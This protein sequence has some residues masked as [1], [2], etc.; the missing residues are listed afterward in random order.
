MARIIIVDDDELITDIV[1][2]VL[3]AAG[4]MI[5]A[6]HDGN[7]A[8][9]A[10]RAGTPDLLIL[11]YTLPGKSGMEILQE[12]RRL[13]HASS[14]PVMMLT[15]CGGRLPMARAD[16]EGADD[17]VVKPFEPD[18]LLRRIEALLRDRRTSQSV[19]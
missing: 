15:A 8:L 2:E 5:S 12:V 9:E 16:R 18:N 11:D 6:I 1:V 19:S 4:H 3:L 7:D 14:M 10:I 13:P 17:Y